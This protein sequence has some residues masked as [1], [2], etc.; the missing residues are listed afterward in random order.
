MPETAKRGDMILIANNGDKTV[1]TI[2]ARNA[3]ERRFNGMRVTVLD[4]ISDTNVG[5]GRAGYIWSA[6]LNDWQLM[7]KSSNKDLKFYTESHVI[8]D[9]A[10]NTDYLPQD[11]IVWGCRIIA[12]DMIVADVKPLVTGMRIEV[13]STDYDGMTLE[14][15]YGSGTANGSICKEGMMMRTAAA[16]VPDGWMLCEGQL[17]SVAD[18]PGLFA[19]IGNRYGGDGIIDFA[20]PSKRGIGEKCIIFT[21]RHPQRVNAVRAIASVHGPAPGNYLAGDILTFG[22]YLLDEV[23]VTGNP[24]IHL[25]IGNTVH[26]LAITGGTATHWDFAD[27]QVASSDAGNVSA[28]LDLNGATLTTKAGDC[29]VVLNV[30][31]LVSGVNVGNAI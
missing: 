23:E 15:T 20:L 21:G 9:G 11:G 8:A 18:Y 2:D 13:G 24:V 19:E 7:W 12:D 3:L 26:Q 17:L 29:A 27:Y 6:A 22:V 25:A 30:L 4:A 28:T 10:I 31:S 14:L 16:R 5:G 1:A